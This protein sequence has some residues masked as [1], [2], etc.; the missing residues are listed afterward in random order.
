MRRLTVSLIA[1]WLCLGIVAQD[2]PLIFPCL[3]DPASLILQD[4]YPHRTWTFPLSEWALM[5]ETVS[6][7]NI[8]VGYD[9]GGFDMPDNAA[10]Q[11]TLY[12]K[13]TDGTTFEVWILDSRD[14]DDAY[15]LMLD[16]TQNDY[17]C[18]CGAWAVDA[19]TLQ[20]WL[21]PIIFGWFGDMEGG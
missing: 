21:H 8:W 1:L 14:T 6:G 16:D 18:G 10:H 3:G 15:L 4:T 20:D 13:R 17:H 2:T 19:R 9:E 11:Y 12:G 7:R 5:A